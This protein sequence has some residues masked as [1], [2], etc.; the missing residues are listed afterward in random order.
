MTLSVDLFWSFRS[1]YSYL[2]T[3][4]IVALRDEYD[5]EVNVRPVYPI[6]VRDPGFFK[7]INPLWVSYLLRD[8]VRVAEMN[9]LRFS[10]PSPDPVVM[11]MQTRTIPKEQP[12]I[13]R[14]TYLGIEAARQSR[15]LE[16]LDEVSRM[17]WGDAVKDWHQGDHLAGAAARAGLDFAAMEAA[18]AA[19]EA[20]YESEI[21]DNQS[22]LEKAGHWGVPTL[23]FEGE[24]FFGQ[25]RIDMC[26]WRMKRKGLI[27]RA[28]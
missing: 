13:H 15:G 4:R 24:P 28:A 25:D 20:G 23:A 8:V 2:A 7:D 16:F 26:V 9:G 17:L 5:L 19:D 21:D 22:A 11:D 18:I 1:P 3:P 12:Y 10:W 6:A 14:L 27:K